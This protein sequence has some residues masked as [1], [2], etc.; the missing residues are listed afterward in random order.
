MNKPRHSA[1]SGRNR[2]VRSRVT[3][4]LLAVLFISWGGPAA[5][6]YWQSLSSSNFG[7]AKAD[8]MP[9]GG[10]PAASLSGANV[11]ISWAAASTP[12][13]HAVTGYTVARYTSASGGT[14]VAAGG[15]CAG[16]VTTL[17]CIEQSVPGGSWFYTVTP[18]IS[19]WA[20]AESARSAAVN[21]DSTP[22]TISVTSISPTPN[23]LGYD[24]TSPV[25]V[26]LAAVDDT[27]GS[28]VANIKYAVDGGSTVTVNAATAAVSVSGDGIH[29]VSFSATD[30]AGNSSTPQTQTV[31][32]DTTAP[33][34]SSVTMVNGGG[35]GNA[36]RASTGDTLTIVFS[37]DMD[38]HTLCSGWD[39]TSASQTANGTASISTAEVLTFTSTSCAVPSFGSV[40]LGAAYNTSTTSSLD[41]TSSTMAWTQS[42]GTLVITLGVPGTGGTAGTGL[43]PATPV[44]SPVTGAADKAGNHVGTITSGGKSKF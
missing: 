43:S 28:G 4:T 9:Q 16:T 6:A 23:G 11:T 12:A 38:P 1:G 17:S 18:V 10:T 3:W 31:N 20:G 7:A 32:I 19:L 25:T 34:V 27:G 8:S 40:A 26:N 14:P 24:N 30:V 44:Y 29:S 35:G 42:T 39:S 37:T 22:P 36:G 2:V 15:G 41:F 21:T 33:T 5:N 13:G